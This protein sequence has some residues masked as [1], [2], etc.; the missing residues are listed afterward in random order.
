[1]SKMT[2][3]LMRKREG[4]RGRGDEGVASVGGRVRGSLLEFGVRGVRRKR[5]MRP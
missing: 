2:S 4:S 1:M 5:L 3:G